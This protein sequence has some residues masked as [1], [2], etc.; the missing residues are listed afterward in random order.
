MLW[1]LYKW[2][3]GLAL[4]L[5]GEGLIPL[6]LSAYGWWPMWWLIEHWPP[7]ERVAIHLRR[8]ELWAWFNADATEGT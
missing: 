1:T 7:M 5:F 8:L 4:P 6:D 2:S 3:A